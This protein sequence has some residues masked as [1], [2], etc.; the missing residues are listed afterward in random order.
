LQLVFYDIDDTGSPRSVTP[1]L[2]K[3]FAAWLKP[4]N[5]TKSTAVRTVHEVI[6][7]D[8]KPAVPGPAA[9]PAPPGV[10]AIKNPGLEEAGKYG[11]PQCWQLASYGENQHEL[12]ILSPGH[13]GTLAR[14]LDVTGYKSGDAKLLPTLD[15]GE[16]SP[17]VEAG[18]AYTVSAYYTS[19]APTQFELYYRNKAGVW[20]Y[21]TAS[22]WTAASSAY[23]QARWTTPAVPADAVGISFGLNLFTNGEL[24]TDDYEMLDAGIP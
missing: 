19:T 15:L 16:C 7:G 8:V 5:E 4:R 21:W 24:A 6:G 3:D 10:N 13:D 22:P 17:S 23:Q 20:T 2:F 18:H 11:L 9:P 14:R 1:Q 12:S